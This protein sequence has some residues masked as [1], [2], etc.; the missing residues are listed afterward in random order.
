MR[1]AFERLATPLVFA[2]L[3]AVV[4]V[5][6]FAVAQA[7]GSLSVDFHNELYPEAKRLLD[8]EN[9]F[10]GPDAELWR[11]HNQI[12]PPVAALLVAPYTLL[13]PGAADWAIAITGL[14]LFMLSLRIVCVRDWR[15]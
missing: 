7:D 12:W 15:V 3:P 4:V 2:V 1:T 11:G 14:A 8:W 5:A 6:M 13:S 10:P 9:P